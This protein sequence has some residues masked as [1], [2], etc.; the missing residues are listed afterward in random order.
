MYKECLY[1]GTEINR[2]KRILTNRIMETSTGDRHWLGNGSYFYEDD[3]YAYK[4]IKDMFKFKFRYDYK[5]VDELFKEYLI[6]KAELNIPKK[7][8]FKLDDVIHK[9]VFDT[10]Y[11]NCENKK[12][13][14]KRFKHT[15][16]VDGVVLNIMFEEMN[17]KEKFDIVIATFKMRENKYK[18]KQMRLN[19][20]PEKQICIKN[21]EVIKP[22]Q[23]LECKDRGLQY[24]ELISKLNFSS[25]KL[26]GTIYNKSNKN[27]RFNI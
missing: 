17:Y 2:G 14:I 19:F 22:N 16:M 11:A 13:Y 6:I 15:K 8:I 20:M 27:R 18:G 1:H 9:I 26:K 23:F 4:W 24:E 5:T 21:I 12:Q 10:V 7:R 3:F 25:E